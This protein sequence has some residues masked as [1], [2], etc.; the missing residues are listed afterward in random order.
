MTT[1][2]LEDTIDVIGASLAL[3]ALVLHKV[4]GHRDLPIRSRRSIYRRPADV[5]W[6][7][8]S[9]AATASCW[10]NQ[11]VA[12]GAIVGHAA[13]APGRPQPGIAAVH[14]IEAVHLG[15]QSVMA[16]AEVEAATAV[17]LTDVAATLEVVRQTLCSDGAG[18]HPPVPH[19]GDARGGGPCAFGTAGAGSAGAGCR[20]PVGRRRRA[21]GRLR[22]R[23]RGAVRRCRPDT[24]SE[25]AW[26]R[27]RPS[28]PTRRRPRWATAP[29]RRTAPPGGRPCPR[30]GASGQQV[31]RHRRVDA[32]RV[33]A[34]GRVA[35]ADHGQQPG[36]AEV[37]DQR[38]APR[39]GRRG[40]VGRGDHERRAG[41]G[42]T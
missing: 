30:P 6:P 29:P 35:V 15:P 32:R 33:A 5:T 26:H 36:V 41:A 10:T 2:Y 8:S 28:A 19:A 27:R 42:R 16:A 1:V 37:T 17:R 3:A 38:L 22:C 14:G 25:P 18:D 11:A 40:V 23:D 39:Y 34:V 12:D 24:C 20:R 13:R 4:Y 31:A 9:A 21:S 7:S